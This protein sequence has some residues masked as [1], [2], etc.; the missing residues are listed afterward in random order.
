MYN[1]STPQY[2]INGLNYAIK[3]N[4][5]TFVHPDYHPVREDKI[6]KWL[7]DKFGIYTGEVEQF[8]LDCTYN[9]FFDWN[10]QVW[11]VQ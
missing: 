6:N 8:V 3:N 2:I 9:V 11:Y 7:C 1:K 10:L 4:P 5:S